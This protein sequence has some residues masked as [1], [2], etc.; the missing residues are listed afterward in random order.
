M[1][2]GAVSANEIDSGNVTMSDDISEINSN[3]QC[4]D[5][6]GSVDSS[7][8]LK[9]DEPDEIIVNDW[10]ELQYYC[11][12][13]DKDYTLRLK[14]NTNFYPSSPTDS[15]YQIKINNNVKII[16]SAGSY[17]GDSEFH[18]CYVPS[19]GFRYVVEGGEFVT[20]TPIVVPDY[21]KKSLTLEN[22]TFKW[23]Y[24]QYSPDAKFIQLGG[25]GNYIFKNCNFDYINTVLGNGAVIALKKGDAILDNC[26]FV[27]CNI[28][29]GLITV[30]ELQPMVVR[31]CYFANN[32]A[33]EHTTCIMNWGK[34]TIYN[35]KFYKN[36]SAAWAGGITTYGAGITNIYNSNFTG[37]VAGW[38]GGA[39][40]VY[41][42]ANI[43][44]T[45]FVDNN[46][47]TNN[48][49]GAIGACKYSGIPRI[50]IEDSLFKNNN[51]LCWALDSLSTTGIGCGGAISLMDEGSLEVRNSLFIA[52]SAAYGTAINAR[53]GGPQYGSPDVIIANNTFINHTRAGDVL[54]I[55]LSDTFYN[56]SGN[57]YFGNSIE[58]SNLTLTSVSSGNEQA[59]LKVTAS[60]ARPDFYEEDIL[61]R[62]W[63]DVY[64]NDE[65][66]KTVNTTMF[67]ID[68]GDFDICDVYVI[69]TI[70][71][72]KTN[73]VTVTSTREY[74]F[75]SKNGNDNNNGSSRSSP[76]NTIKKALELAKDCRNIILLDGNWS[77]NLKID[78]DVLIKGENNATL[79]N[80][81]Q[82]VLNSNF[83]LKNMNII[84]LS[85]D[86]FIKQN[87]GNL[88]IENCIFKNNA[89]VN[90]ID[91]RHAEI[92]KSI[93]I[94]N[95]A[96][97][98]NNNGYAS[99]TNSVILNN[100]DILK[101]NQNHVLDYNWWGSTL[102]NP[103]KPVDLNISNWLVLNATSSVNR[104]EQNQ[105]ALI[106]LGFY[107]NNAS[108]YTNLPEIEFN[109][110][111]LNGNL[112]SGLVYTLT[113]LKNGV[114]TVNY[115]DVYYDITFE[116]LKSNPNLQVKTENV[117]FGEDVVIQ[118]TMPGDVSGN[119]TVEIS[120]LTQTMKASKNM[121]FTF[122]N[123]KADNYAVNAIFSGDDKYIPQNVTSNVQVSR[124]PS[125]INLEIGEIKVNEDVLI[126][127]S[128]LSDAQ[129]N[130]T[131]YINNKAHTLVL[132]NAKAT[133]TI[134]NIT[135][136]DYIIKAVYNG[137]DKYLESQS[138]TKI[139]VDNLNA[140]M[141]IGAKDI[142]YG[143]SA[144]ITVRLNDNA[145]GNVTVT[146]D[147]KYNSS[148]VVDGQ[149]VI[150]LSGL[151]AG[152]NKN[153]TVF[154]TGDD[155][156]F[157]KTESADFTIS[158][159][160]LT[161]DIFA[162]NIKIGQ[163]AV[164][165]INVPAKTSGTFTIGEDV[166]T[167]PLS[168]AVEY[169][170][171]DLAIGEYE[172]TAIYDGNNYNT[173]Q[174]STTFTVL[175][176]PISQWP[177]EGSD[178]KSSYKSQYGSDTNGEI[179]FI[180][181]LEEDIVGALTIDSDGNIYVTT[182][183]GIYSYD[184]DGSLRFVFTPDTREGN[185]SGTCIGRDVVISPK[186][187]DTLY[188]INQTTGEK[189]GSSNLYQGSSIFSPII[190]SNANVYIVSEYQ[191]TSGRY[192]LVKIPYS[193]WEFGGN[194]I[195]VDLAKTAPL[196]SPTVNENIVV[197]LSENRLMVLD[198]NTL[199]SNFIKSGNYANVRPVIGEGNIVYA[200]LSD[201]VVAY[202]V[203][204]SQL[205]KSKIT[206]GVRQLLLDEDVLYSLNA[207]GKLY[208][209]DV[210][211]GKQGLVSNLNITSGVLIGNDSNL[212]F[213]SNN[214][215]YMVSGDGEI[216]WKSDLSTKITGNPIMDKN[217]VIYVAS[218]DNRIFALTCGD[219]KDPNLTVSVDD[220]QIT[221]SIDSQA[222]GRVSFD[223]NDVSYENVFN[224]PISDLAEGKYQI[225]VT[226]SGD[227][228]FRQTSEIVTFTVKSEVVP[229]IESNIKD[230]VSITLCK[231]ATGNLTVI[232]GNNTYIQELVDGMATITVPGLDSM[233]DVTVIYSGDSK[234][235]GFNKTTN[236]ALVKSK[237]T[238][239][240]LNMLYSSGK[241]FKVR[242][243]Q[244]SNPLAGKTVVFTVNG[245]KISRI[246]NADGYA[247]VKI[248]LAPKTYAVTAEYNGVKVKN[249]VVVKSIITAKN[250][251]AKK[252]SK[253]IKIKVT[254]K[255]VNKK[256][257]KN[258]KVTL[259]FNKKT[260]KA[261]TNNKGVVTFT[262]KKN[263][264]NK[265]KA[266]KKYTYQAIYGK[267]KVKKTIKFKK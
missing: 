184:A 18:R 32:F 64:I 254:L 168:G 78:Y 50:Y 225:N 147:G 231:D 258:K 229:E 69:P 141:E 96:A 178:S 222:T 100:T 264:Y 126:S 230:T 135:R 119:V 2:I 25:N 136:G 244:N 91:A 212:Y 83:T 257:L 128:C 28:P 35:T 37:N 140:S 171:S 49:G 93:I 190:D 7:D 81:T 266:N 130:V 122:K 21:N 182:Q 56:V 209:Y 53:D 74:V 174:N 137:D 179:A 29:K 196:C 188:F 116:F 170:I 199:Q 214:I 31:D 161:F 252:S 1:S 232:A 110:N 61:D 101:G 193:M 172:I 10:D 113:A 267:D 228:R 149:S 234:Y 84:N 39:L 166:I 38:N 15:N 261:K 249:K 17:I 243:T 127:V 242:L 63:Y 150:I 164:I 26:S 54:Y 227:L 221:I 207:D 139:E 92:S 22:V 97:L 62:T 34:L 33:Y 146:V 60:L 75:V 236:V 223:F 165:H 237:L 251:N 138:S 36:R 169:V 67:T 215:F 105:V 88:I 247:S 142:I 211:T 148:G 43:Y 253:S 235:S 52:N 46:C 72:R 4:L 47:T 71:N 239:N 6:I 134:K 55:N 240:N 14:E 195:L 45:T 106:S 102:K 13:T 255:K 73:V 217:G 250:V 76:V 259:K 167:I 154:Y 104:L 153:I 248:T 145:T 79:T 103:A 57:K 133:Y 159:A 95:N 191:V 155:T 202:S 218:S 205:W 30:S 48:G 158:K 121:I 180:I 131:L 68:F 40:Y 144:V 175:E 162:D 80:A 210:L 89:A 107:L 189:Y 99:I 20:Y 246:T 112:D 114:V 245:K 156:Y 160:D 203:S 233:G 185:F 19:D 120:N 27:N 206:S 12:L 24:L 8:L 220:S 216:L 115:N 197:V 201:S 111:A 66:V 187:G 108:K 163:D 129:G 59:T 238:A 90:L 58:F 177:N 118:I 192:N 157:N 86:N 5:E 213:A 82:F 3:S 51:N 173:V 219:L 70:S 123:L 194:P 183:N 109:Y 265:L 42:I 98:I 85:V 9:S 117:M 44:N 65:Y 87:D 125:K 263:V 132:T 262:I 181:D 16:G 186:S 176:Y 124:Y 241:Y 41:N 23:V 200:A 77:E 11:S 198:A 152:A 260:F 94:N 143:E 204:G 208:R 226:Y 151:E 224:I 256:Y